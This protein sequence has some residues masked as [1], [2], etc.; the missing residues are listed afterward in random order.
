MHPP[1]ARSATSFSCIAELDSLRVSNPLPGGPVSA[2]TLSN[3][4]VGNLLRHGLGS[5]EGPLMVALAAQLD[6]LSCLV[7]PLA[8]YMAFAD[9]SGRHP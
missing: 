5:A 1:P 2:V 7:P 4:A 9:M 3:L 8:Q 6:G